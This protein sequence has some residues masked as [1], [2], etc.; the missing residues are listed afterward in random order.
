MAATVDIHC[1]C[2]SPLAD[3]GAI[4]GGADLCS[5]DNCEYSAANRTT[6]PIILGDYS[7]EKWLRA[8]V[9]VLPDNWL[10]RFYY[11]GDGDIPV[12]TTLRAGVTAA[13]PDPV[14]VPSIIA[15][16]DF[17]L[18]TDLYRGVWDNA[19]YSVADLTA[20]PHIDNFL[21]FQLY[22]SD[23]AIPGEWG[24]EVVYYEYQEV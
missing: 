24:P 3:D 17:S 5:A 19:V 14:N 20:D 12:G 10:G 4:A 11:W 21:V 7:Y 16:N 15:V 8:H 22:A 2:G 1:Y 6:N 9:S 18:F 13:T 23:T